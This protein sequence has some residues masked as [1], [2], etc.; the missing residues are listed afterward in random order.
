MSV[1]EREAEPEAHRHAEKLAATE[2]GTVHAA[3]P[4]HARI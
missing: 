4:W 3:E 1:A 2:R